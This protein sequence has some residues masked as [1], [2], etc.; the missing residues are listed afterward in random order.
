MCA[1]HAP[2]NEDCTF[3]KFKIAGKASFE[4]HWNNHQFC[5]AWCQAKG[6]NEEEKKKYKHK[7]RDKVRNMREYE[8]QLIIVTKF[9]KDKRMAQVYHEWLNTKTESIHGL[10][11][12]ICLPKRSYYFC[13]TIC[14]GKARTFLA[15]SINSLGY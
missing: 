7:Y 14:C 4:H 6:W 10:I 11:V 12:N 8:Q 9:T 15:V 1:Q 13:Q 2:G 5:G 3:E